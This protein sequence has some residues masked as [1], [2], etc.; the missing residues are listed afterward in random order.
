MLKLCVE[1]KVLEELDGC[2][3]V[4]MSRGCGLVTFWGWT[5]LQTLSPAKGPWT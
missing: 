4:S 2:L 1:H 5:L 3:G